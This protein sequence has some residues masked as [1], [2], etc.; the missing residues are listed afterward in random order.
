T[1][2]IEYIHTSNQDIMQEKQIQF[3]NSTTETIFATTD[4]AR[5]EQ[6]FNNLIRNSVDFV[7]GGGM[8]EIGAKGDNKKIVCYVKDNGIGIPK[9]KQTNLFN[10]F[11]QVDSS[12]RRKHGGTGLGLSISQGIIKGLGGKIWVESESK[13][14][15]IFYFEV[16]KVRAGE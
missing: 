15:S 3:V 9:E 5:L 6:V 1:K 14:G 16:P 7:R 11:Y 12:L 8:I 2:L 13:K 4:G 10:R